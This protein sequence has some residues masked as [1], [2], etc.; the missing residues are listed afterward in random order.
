MNFTVKTKFKIEKLPQLITF[1]GIDGSGK[2]TQSI[3]LA[4]NLSKAGY[5]VKHVS[6]PSSNSFGTA[7][8]A[9]SSQVNP[10]VKRELFL[11]D[12][13]QTLYESSGVFDV[14]VWDRYV[15][16][17]ITSNREFTIED[18]KQYYQQIPAPM[19]TFY[20]DIDPATIKIKRAES[21]HDHSLDI[22]WQQEKR[23]NYRKLFSEDN[24][25]VRVLDADQDKL[26]ISQYVLN[27]T[28]ITLKKS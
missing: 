13:I 25:R 24:M 19:L 5:S 8:R 17:G 14:L 3:M 11:L 22:S 26:I 9:L 23:N 2:T 28:L 6:N 4:D 15:D 20:L 1:E 16:S 7:V 10:I 21:V 27:E 18:S 12:I